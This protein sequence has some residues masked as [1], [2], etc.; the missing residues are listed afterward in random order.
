M[1]LDPDS[2]DVVPIPAPKAPSSPT[3]TAGFRRAR[4]RKRLTAT[5]LIVGSGAAAVTLAYDLIPAATPV[6]GTVAST[7]GV[8]TTTVST[9]NGGPQVK[10]TVATT[11][12]SGV[13]TTTTSRVV[14]G[15]TVVTRSRS[16]PASHDR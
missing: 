3:S 10:H 7:S 5:A 2:H 16:A 9:A 6:A 14:N 8:G 15:R 11:S 1:N 12:A 4:R 13:T